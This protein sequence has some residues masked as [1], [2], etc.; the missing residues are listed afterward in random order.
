[1]LELLL[2]RGAIPN[3]L[4]ATESS[5]VKLSSPLLYA[6]ENMRPGQ[7]EAKENPC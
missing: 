2:S 6:L 1:M 5:T 4:I 7:D 3:R